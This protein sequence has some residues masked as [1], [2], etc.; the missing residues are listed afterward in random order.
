MKTPMHL[1][2]RASAVMGL[3]WLVLAPLSGPAQALTPGE[4]AE[5]QNVAADRVE[6]LTVLGGDYG[7]AGGTYI[8]DTSGRDVK[9]S[10][11]KFGGMGDI[12][13]PRPLGDTG[14]GWQPRL[15]G[16]MGYV[17]STIDYKSGS[18]D[19]DTST[20]KTF[21]IQFGG[22]A[23]FWFNDHLSLAPTFMGMYGHTEND[24]DA[25]SIRGKQVLEQAKQ[26]GLVNYRVDTW[27]VRPAADVQY[28]HTWGRTVFSLSSELA[29][30]HTESF[31]TSK[32]AN[33]ING[34]SETW[35]NTIDVDVP[36]GKELWGHEL[37]T[38]GFLSRTELYGDVEDGLGT[39]HI[40]E[41][42]GRVVLDF[43][44]KLWKVQW[45]GIGGSY[46]WGSNFY[47]YSF[48]ADIAFRF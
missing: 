42:H 33:S 13:D 22:G 19:D 2:L 20:Y 11:S 7:V 41:A 39:D 1:L 14:I 26:A 28:V 43:L 18:F 25:D 4:V 23:R 44:G 9:L 46:L 47:G 5:L 38:G 21:A 24:Y 17:E 6:A 3:S 37:R 10:V 12:G 48:G 32:Y 29:Y 16:S 40:Y 45:I 31:R 27:T 34:D 15:Q 8:P 36:L 30:F 35:K